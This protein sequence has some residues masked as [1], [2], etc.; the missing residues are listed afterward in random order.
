MMN[1]T[2][3]KTSSPINLKKVST[4]SPKTAVKKKGCGCGKK[5]SH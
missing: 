2:G 3:N 5:S 1:R 4:N